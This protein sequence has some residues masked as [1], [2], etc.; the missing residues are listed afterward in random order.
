M[1]NSHL[2]DR[3]TNRILLHGHPLTD[4]NTHSIHTSGGHLVNN[5]QSVSE[6]GPGPAFSLT[7]APLDLGTRLVPISV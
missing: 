1:S 6:T 2:P 4:S 5:Q 3:S 7:S